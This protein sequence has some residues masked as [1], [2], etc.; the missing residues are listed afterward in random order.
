MRNWIEAHHT[1]AEG[2]PMAGQKYKA[3]F[4]DGSVISGALDAQ[5]HARHDNVP[6]K[7]MRIEYEPRPVKPESKADGATTL[8]DAWL[9]KLN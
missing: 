7:A 5:G 9:G 4:E 1:D 2:Q 3:Y 8:A 6:G